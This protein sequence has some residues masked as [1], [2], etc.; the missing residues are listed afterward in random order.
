MKIGIL[1]I[2]TGRYITFWHNFYK[3]V[4][5][6]ILPEYEKH[7]FV[8][9]DS[10]D[11]IIG[12]DKNVTKIFQ[13]KLGWPYD[14]LMRFDIFLKA[15]KELEKM[16]YIYFFNANIEVI[17]PIGEEILPKKEGLMAV[18]HPLQYNRSREEFS[19]ETD[20]KSLAYIPPH[21]G[22]Y[23]FMGGLNGGKTKEYLQ[24]VRT[25]D[26][27]IKKDLEN[28]VIA[29]WHDE[30][31]INKYLLDKEPLIVAP[32]YAWPEG[33]VMDV[34]DYKYYVYLK[35][36]DDIK[37]ILHNKYHHRFGGAVWMRN[38]PHKNN[39]IEK[40]S[41]IVYSELTK[42]NDFYQ[43]YQYQKQN[44]IKIEFK[45]EVYKKYI[46]LKRLILNRVKNSFK[47]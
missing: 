27:N 41:F 42:C 37:I 36:V 44:A 35:S 9:T 34:P 19:Y 38:N 26:S 40:I 33:L 18:R 25:L 3:S 7:Y 11:K 32:Q 17:K 23:Y 46:A 16:N 6:Y 12:E 13:E 29:V 1:Y 5:K 8:F 2:A 47:L 20:P 28:D 30:S 10:K 45:T 39:F 22:K 4:E 24:L 31:H 21:Q 15:E 43:N 14:T